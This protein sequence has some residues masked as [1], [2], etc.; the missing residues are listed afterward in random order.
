MGAAA[1]VGAGLG[2]GGSSLQMD[3][4]RKQAQGEI[5]NLHKEA[6]FL[7][8][9]AEFERTAGQR[10]LK[11]LRQDSAELFGDQVSAFAKN[12]VNLSG[13][14]LSEVVTSQVRMQEEAEAIQQDID[15]NSRVSS[16][17]VKALEEAAMDVAKAEKR[18]RVATILGGLTS[19]FGA[20]Q[21]GGA[22]DR[23]P[24]KGG[25]EGSGPGTGPQVDKRISSP[26]RTGMNRRSAT[27][28][29]IPRARRE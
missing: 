27:S 7:E 17:R 1:V 19:A 8:E 20:A 22:F 16:M 4:Q 2:L 3:A 12:G 18:G 11:L 26:R 21:A 24:S 5:K 13:S 29:H 28:T 6:S 23:A 14:A 25:V 9:Q 15:F 10:R